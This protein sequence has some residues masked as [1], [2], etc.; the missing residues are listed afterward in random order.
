MV[1]PKPIP[2]IVH[3]S[4][5]A[6]PQHVHRISN[7]FPTKFIRNHRPAQPGNIDRF[8]PHVKKPFNNDFSLAAKEPKPESTF[9]VEQVLESPT[10]NVETQSVENQQMYHG[11]Y[12][13]PSYVTF[14]PVTFTTSEPVVSE[15]AVQPYTYYH[16]GT[17]FWYL[18]LYFTIAFVVLYG[19]LI[20]VNAAFRKWHFS[21]AKISRSNIGLMEATEHVLTAIEKAGEMISREIMN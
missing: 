13:N 18:P 16:I 2:D 17:K 1:T 5:I 15:D 11:Y 19:Y 21:T 14:T 4:E 20:I 12:A 8:N 7:F 10:Y 3:L 9:F 6:N